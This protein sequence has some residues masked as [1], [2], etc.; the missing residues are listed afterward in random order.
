M[1][2]SPVTT[3]AVDL[4]DIGADARGYIDASR[5]ENTARSYRTGWDQFTA[6]CD[7]HGLTSLPA[8][9]GCFC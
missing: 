8:N 2:L 7:Q 6:W 1:A 5:A 9:L 4:A 3:L